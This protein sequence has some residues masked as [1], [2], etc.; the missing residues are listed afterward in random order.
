MVLTD[1]EWFGCIYNLKMMNRLF[2]DMEGM[3]CLRL[4]I[5]EEI[6]NIRQAKSVKPWKRA[7][8]KLVFIN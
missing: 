4:A 1:E 5:S 7:Y 2:E 8:A 3:K 6:R